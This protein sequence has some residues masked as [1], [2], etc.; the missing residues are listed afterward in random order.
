MEYLEKPKEICRKTNKI[1]YSY[2]DANCI[3]KKKKKNPKVNFNLRMYH[4]TYCNA[5]H[6]TSSEKMFEHHSKKIKIINEVSIDE[7][8]SK[9]QSYEI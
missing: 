9:M 8:R 4:C 7:I 5:W 2:Y 6:F 3:Y 1:I